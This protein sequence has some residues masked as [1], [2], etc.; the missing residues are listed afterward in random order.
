MS[1]PKETRLPAF[2][3]LNHRGKT[4]VFVDIIPAQSDVGTS[5]TTT[6]N[7]NESLAIL[8]YLETYHRPDIPLLPPITY[9]EQRAL[10]LSRLQETEN[11]HHAYDALEDAHFSAAN[12]ASAPLSNAER[13]RLI[14][15]VHS[16]LDFWEVYAGKTKF[17]AGNEFGLADCALFPILAYMVHRGFEWRRPTPGYEPSSVRETRNH[18]K[19]GKGMGVPQEV[20]IDA[21]PKLKAY[22]ERVWDRNGENGCAQRAQPAGWDRRGKAN[23]WKGTIGNAKPLRKDAPQPAV[24]PK[25]EP[26]GPVD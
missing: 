21:W 16:E 9:R 25:C 15:D 20:E 1:N 12:K 19:K 14:R 26:E 8:Q 11:L 24:V 10:V 4:P 5:T 23:V 2:L 7:V 22:F 17:I 18:D 3:A 13:A 6:I